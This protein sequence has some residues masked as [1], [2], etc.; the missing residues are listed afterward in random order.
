MKQF[1]K[2]NWGVLLAIVLLIVLVLASFYQYY[3][4]NFSYAPKYYQTLE[5]CGSNGSDPTHELCKY[6]R[7]DEDLE[8]MKKENDPVVK[9]NNLDAITL[10]SEIV[11][12]N[13]FNCLQYFS[14][15]LIIISVVSIFHK[16]FS[17]GFF[18]N[19]LLRMNHKDYVK[20]Q[21]RIPWK[22]ALLIPLTLLFVFAISCF[23]TKFNFNTTVY[24]AVY[25]EFKYNHFFLYGITILFVQYLLSV[26]YG[27][28]A[29]YSCKKSKNSL[30]SI[31]LGYLFFLALELFVMLVLYSLII[32]RIFGV[33]E[34]TDMFNIAGYWFFTNM[35]KSLWVF[36]LPS[37]LVIL[38]TIFLYR[39]YYSKEG[40][41]L[42]YEKQVE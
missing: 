1:I 13:V 32:N 37:V 40:V 19:K 5:K 27:N 34:L 12:N 23:I 6:I 24:T 20:K 16:D 14:P 22:V 18:E 36:I 9:Y 35:N 28:I 8:R 2:K 25:D 17:S 10:T 7:D 41:I 26:V 11:E 31:I 29:M 15:L 38:S 21:M 30:L 39:S 33:K 4:D 42:S 3:A